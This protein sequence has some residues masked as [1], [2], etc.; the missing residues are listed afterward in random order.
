MVFLTPNPG[1]SSYKYLVW[2]LDTTLTDD[3]AGTDT[4]KQASDYTIVWVKIL[5]NDAAH[6]NVKIRIG[7]ATADQIELSALSRPDTDVMWEGV[8]SGKV[9]V[10]NAAALASGRLKILVG[11]RA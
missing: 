10:S 7:S 5:R 8:V 6:D 4:T 11:V 3:V 2:N 1:A 9:Y